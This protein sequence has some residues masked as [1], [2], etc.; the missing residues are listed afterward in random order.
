[1][2]RQIVATSSNWG[3]AARAQSAQ[4][5]VI[6]QDL[7]PGIK[8]LVQEEISNGEFGDLSQSG[9]G[10]L[11]DTSIQAIPAEEYLNT[12]LSAFK[13]KVQEFVQAFA[14]GTTGQQALNALLS[15]QTQYAKGDLTF[16]AWKDLA[17]ENARQ[18]QAS[19]NMLPGFQELVDDTFGTGIDGF[20]ATV[21]RRLLGG[22]TDSGQTI[23]GMFSDATREW[24]DS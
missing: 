24:I 4:T 18:L 6:I 16:G 9:I 21:E 23:P 12:P 14:D 8:A 1:M 17:S 10:F 19:G 20:F 5:D 7:W 15:G 22:A 11:V 3:T 2:A 13:S